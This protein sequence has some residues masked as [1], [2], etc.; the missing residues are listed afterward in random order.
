MNVPLTEK[1]EKVGNPSNNEKA[2]AHRANILEKE[3]LQPKR[4]RRKQDNQ[5]AKEPVNFQWS[6]DLIERLGH[7]VVHR[8]RVEGRKVTM[9]KVAEKAVDEFLT[10]E[11]YPP[12][13]EDS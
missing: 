2:E 11:G 13:S 3:L 9:S 7:Y 4:G 5:V 6:P 1:L 12:L 8:K 10:K